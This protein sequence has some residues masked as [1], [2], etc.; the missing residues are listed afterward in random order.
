MPREQYA[1][2]YAGLKDDKLTDAFRLIEADIYEEGE[3]ERII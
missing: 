1:R 3:F 2:F